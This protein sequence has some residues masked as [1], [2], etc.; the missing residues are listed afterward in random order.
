MKAAKANHVESAI[1]SVSFPKSLADD[2]KTVEK[3]EKWLDDLRAL[4]DSGGEPLS[5]TAPSGMKSGDVLFFYL[6][7]SSE[8]N[9][10]RLRRNLDD[11]TSVGGFL[12]KAFAKH[13]TRSFRRS[14]DEAIE[15]AEEYAGRVFACGE[16]VGRPAPEA[17]EPGYSPRFES[18][19][20]A[21][22]G[23]VHVFDA[24]LAYDELSRRVGI[25][26]GAITALHGKSFTHVKEGLSIRNELPTFLR[27]AAPAAHEFAGE[28]DWEDVAR[29]GELR[30]LDED[31]MRKLL[32]DPMLEEIKDRESPVFEECR[33]LY[34][35]KWKGVA[36]Y[37]VEVGGAW[38]PVETKRNILAEPDITKQIAAY[39]RAQ[40]FKPTRGSRKGKVFERPSKNR[41]DV[42]LVVDYSGVYIVSHEGFVGCS[43][44]API[45]K[46][47]ELGH[48]LVPEIRE[49]LMKASG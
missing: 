10:K 48:S 1:T 45:R 23:R 33:C 47:E 3:V 21:P 6:T 20:F 31:H 36:D 15:M 7:K 24:P 41:P 30:F 9:L 14:L 4:R 25:R 13:R 35:K 11:E 22:V 19:L 49:R 42:C 5:W 46:R 40:K 17:P 38:L 39:T 12:R 32:V 8:V 37:F 26:Q 16:V 34:R 18:R 29:K 2:P 27:N 44:E 43:P 28:G